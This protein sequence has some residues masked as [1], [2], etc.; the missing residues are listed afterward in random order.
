MQDKLEPGSWVAKLFHDFK[1]T[2]LTA[3]PQKCRRIIAQAVRPEAPAEIQLIYHFWKHMYEFQLEWER[4]GHA[5]ALATA[6]RVCDVLEQPLPTWLSEAIFNYFA[7]QV[8]ADE[9]HQLDE[10]EDHFTRWKAVIE[11]REKLTPRRKP[12]SLEDCYATVAE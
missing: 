10:F 7:E 6:L 2:R 12:P 1:L 5:I 4:T 8:T 11:E 3:D 9:C